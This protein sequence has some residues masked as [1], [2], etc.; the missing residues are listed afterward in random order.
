MNSIDVCGG[1]NITDLC[2]YI[3]VFAVEEQL[4]IAQRQA[5]V[6]L[7]QTIRC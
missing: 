6:V 7:V 5:G 4:Q 1:L 2:K 3:A